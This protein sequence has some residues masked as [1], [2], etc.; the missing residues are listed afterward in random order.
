[1]SI[2]LKRTPGSGRPHGP[3]V[4]LV[5]QRFGTWTVKEYI[6]LSKWNCVCIC[7]YEGPRRSGDLQKGRSRQCWKCGSKHSGIKRLLP[8]GE[9]AFNQVYTQYID[10]AK[11]RNLIWDLDKS[12][13]R[14]FFSLP[15][16]Y[17]GSEPKNVYPLSRAR[18]KFLYN[19]IDR[20]DPRMGYVSTNC[21]PCCKLCN[22]MKMAL[23][24][25]DFISHVNKIAVSLKEFPCP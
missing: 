17:C 15:C 24:K 5:G 7:G 1:M 14:F 11:A 25:E 20:I 22:R 12:L 18:G 6:G 16:I 8:E 9:A 4:D 13:V 19:G 3:Q 2:T 21:A 10:N 23:S